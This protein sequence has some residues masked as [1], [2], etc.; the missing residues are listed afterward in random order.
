QI[1]DA[2]AAGQRLGYP[3]H[4]KEVVGPRENEPTGCGVL[5]NRHL[6]VGHQVR[7]M[8]DLVDDQGTAELGQEPA[9]IFPGEPPLVDRFQGDIAMGGKSCAGQGCFAGLARPGKG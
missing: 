7:C 3:A 8:L 1:E 6:D 5:V 4:E 9:G 2:A